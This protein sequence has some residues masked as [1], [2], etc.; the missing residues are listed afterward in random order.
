MVLTQM[1]DATLSTDWFKRLQKCGFNFPDSYIVLDTESTGLKVAYDY[2]V[3]FGHLAVV[4]RIPRK[5]T[6]TVLDWTRCPLISHGDFRQRLYE[7]EHDIRTHGGCYR[8]SYERVAKEGID[9]I[10]VLEIYHDLFEYHQ[11]TGSQILTH[12]GIRFDIQIVKHQFRRFLGSTFEFDQEL[13]VDT[14]LLEKA[15]QLDLAPFKNESRAS[16]YQRINAVP[17][18]GVYW[19]LDKHCIPMYDLG[20]KY[21]LDM[22]QAHTAGFDCYITHLLMEEIRERGE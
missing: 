15:R 2:V 8:F 5:P 10:S 1:P 11:S 9:P 22:S 13:V 19:S 17:G 16:Y 12:N 14:G 6:A 21:C 3:Q 7:T 20:R 4:D 18:K